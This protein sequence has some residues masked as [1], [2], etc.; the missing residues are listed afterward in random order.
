MK[1]RSTDLSG[2]C[3]YNKNH[4]AFRYIS[5][6][7]FKI[8]ERFQRKASCFPRDFA[9]LHLCMI[10]SLPEVERVWEQHASKKKHVLVAKI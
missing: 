6:K 1:I 8:S 2:E 10:N 7:G 5:I 9:I 3:C 4:H